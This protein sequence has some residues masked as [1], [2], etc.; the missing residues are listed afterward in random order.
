M[1]SDELQ[2]LDMFIFFSLKQPDCLMIC[3]DI[4]AGRNATQKAD[5]SKYVYIPQDRSFAAKLVKLVDKP[6]QWYYS[7]D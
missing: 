3:T 1:P 2:L 4:R 7:S 5:E 6:S